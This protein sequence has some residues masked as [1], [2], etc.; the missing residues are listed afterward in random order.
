MML[1]VETTNSGLG[2]CEEPMRI[3]IHLALPTA[4][5]FSLALH[6]QRISDISRALA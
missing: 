3:L 4:M 1:R 2:F 5:V 6:A